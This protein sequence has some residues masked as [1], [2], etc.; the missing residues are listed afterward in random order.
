M[1]SLKRIEPGETIDVKLGVSERLSIQKLTMVEPEIAE[2]V[3]KAPKEPPRIP[4]TLDELDDL[5]GHVAAD[6][7]HTT[8]EN[9]KYWLEKLYS[10]IDYVLQRYTDEPEPSREKQEGVL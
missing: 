3:A 4:F 5:I 2:R 7:N 1:S 8:D 10:K 6:L 9:R